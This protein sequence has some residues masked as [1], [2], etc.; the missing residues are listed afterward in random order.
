MET[1]PARGTIK[2]PRVTAVTARPVA[3][4]APAEILAEARLAAQVAAIP[5]VA[6]PAA[7]P[8]VDPAGFRWNH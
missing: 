6:R 1:G 7:I 3:L 8:E 5:E 4:G 2:A